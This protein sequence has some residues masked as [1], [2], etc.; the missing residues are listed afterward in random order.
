MGSLPLSINDASF[1]PALV[2]VTVLAKLSICVV[3]PG[4]SI[5]NAGNKCIKLEVL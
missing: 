3:A 4:V 2:P 5:P 1:P